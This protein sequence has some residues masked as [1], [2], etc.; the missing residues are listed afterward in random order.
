[1]PCNAGIHSK[2]PPTA[3]PFFIVCC[4][5][6]HLVVIHSV[7]ILPAADWFDPRNLLSA[8]SVEYHLWMLRMQS[9]D[10][11]YYLMDSFDWLLL[12]T[13]RGVWLEVWP[14][15]NVAVNVTDVIVTCVCVCVWSLLP[16]IQIAI[17]FD[18]ISISSVWN[19]TTSRHLIS[20]QPPQRNCAI[21]Y[22]NIKQK[23]ESFIASNL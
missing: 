6:F 20:S 16:S 9:A 7:L 17:A 14:I 8:S 12:L 3:H 21:F 13:L 11:C 19:W 10:V 1:M 4:K 23:W 22:K 2:W 18:Y 5:E 15:N